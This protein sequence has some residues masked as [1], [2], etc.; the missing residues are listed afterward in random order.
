MNSI[1][2]R[3]L[4]KWFSLLTTDPFL[5]NTTI[6][7]EETQQIVGVELTAKGIIQKFVGLDKPDPRLWLFNDRIGGP[8][9]KARQGDLLQVRFQNQ[10]PVLSIIHWHGIRNVNAM[11]GVAG[12][13]QDPVPPGGEFTYTVLLKDAG[14]YYAHTMWDRLLVG[15]MVR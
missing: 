4:L 6:K 11:D 9:L 12:L 14:T 7:A 1:K 2:R 13:T 8:F 10:L 5:K 3:D 15:C